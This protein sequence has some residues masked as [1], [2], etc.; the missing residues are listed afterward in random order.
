MPI[1]K[2]EIKINH[3]P[4]IVWEHHLVMCIYMNKQ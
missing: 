1:I 2:R 3:I 4:V